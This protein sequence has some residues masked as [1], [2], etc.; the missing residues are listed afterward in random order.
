MRAAAMTVG[1][2]LRRLAIGFISSQEIPS[3]ENERRFHLFLECEPLGLPSFKRLI[4]G[5]LGWGAFF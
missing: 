3:V 1:I 2:I 5:H 4:R